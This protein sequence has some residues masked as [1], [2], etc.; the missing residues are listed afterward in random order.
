MSQSTLTSP[1]E[2]PTNP[3]DALGT[4]RIPLSIVSAV[5]NAEE[6]LA[7]LEGMCKYGAHNF[8]VIGVRASI[9]LDA[10]ARHLAKYT[11]G[12]D[13]DPKTGVHHLGSVRACTGI[14]LDTAARG[15]LTDDRPPSQHDFSDYID[16]L[17]KRVKHLKE[18]F[19]DRNPR[20]YTKADTV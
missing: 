8:R 7:L 20:H 11:L 13:R 15:L 14:I 6:A 3:K 5:A 12:E 2:K 1:D 17:E 10:A 19:K 9:Y 18:I 4:D 16:N